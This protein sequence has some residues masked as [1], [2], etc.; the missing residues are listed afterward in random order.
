[1]NAT[2]NMVSNLI[3][4]ETILKIEGLAEPIVSSEGCKLYDIEFSGGGGG[5]IL[6]VYIDKAVEGGPTLDDCAKVS[7]ALNAL[8]DEGDPI[9][10]GNYHL[11]VSTPGIERPLRKPW[12]FAEVSGKKIWMQLNQRLQDFGLQNQKIANS[13]KLEEVVQSSD[14]NGVRFKIEDEEILIPFAAIEKAHVVYE[15]NP[16]AK[17]PEKKNPN[18]RVKLKGKKKKN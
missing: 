15:F 6:R 9:P 3:S 7:R 8:L 2:L 4:T 16:N 10:G 5:R 17:K 18:F 14:E 13:K 12:H 1:L 11:E